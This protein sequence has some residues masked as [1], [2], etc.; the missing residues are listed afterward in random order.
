[1]PRGVPKNRTRVI[2]NWFI[3]QLVDS[4]DIRM[5]K[6]G[7]LP[8]DRKV[9][10]RCSKC[11]YEVVTDLHSKVKLST[12]EVRRGCYKCSKVKAMSKR[13]A[14]REDFPKW[15]LDSIVDDK[16]RERVR[17]K[18]VLL[19]DKI[20]FKCDK[21]HIYEM[22]LN[23]RIVRSTGKENHGC[24]I[25]NRYSSHRSHWEDE[26]NNLI[27]SDNKFKVYKNYNG[28]ILFGN[29]HG[30]LDLYYPELHLAIE[31]NG[32]YWHSTKGPSMKVAKDKE[33]HRYKFISCKEHGIRLISL[34]DVDYNDKVKQF[35]KEI[36]TTKHRYYA[37]K[38]VIKEVP[39]A[40]ARK[41]CDDYHLLGYSVQGNIRYGLYDGDN[42]IALMTFGTGRYG[43][44]GYE[45]VRYVVKSNCLVVGGSSRLLKRFESE[46]R[47]DKLVSYSD[48]DYFMGTMYSNLGFKYDGQTSLD[49]YWWNS[50][51]FKRLS[52]QECSV[53]NLK[54]LYSN[55][56][57]ED[58]TMVRLGY[59]K[60]YRCGNTR[61]V[62]EYN[63]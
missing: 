52:R 46:Y 21:G 9:R 45:L 24:Y 57:T 30:E 59:Y 5:A 23:D 58:D 2:P 35:L 7:T 56:T 37:R 44:S 19:T 29:R 1:M 4:D 6:N 36:V 42:L 27:N 8:P 14:A 18:Q 50:R 43:V 47:P 41:F 51:T 26:V 54:K 62:K 11:G 53:K 13:R 55:V 15:L 25:C 32:S 60:I 22:K 34:F 38:L 28:I 39:L 63:S 12:G 20:K 61:W 40:T 33:Y 10:F 16:D 17:N 49:Y 48:N 3:E 31:C